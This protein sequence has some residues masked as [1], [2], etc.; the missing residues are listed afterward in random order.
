[1][2]QQ[3][4]RGPAGVRGLRLGRVAG[5]TVTLDWSLLI[6]FALITLMLS[7]GVLPVWHPDWGRFTVLFTAASA[8]VLFLASILVHELSHAVVGRRMGV[9]VEHITLFVFGGMAHMEEEPRTW[10]AELAMAIAGPITSLLLGFA[11]ISLAGLVSGPL[12]VNPEAP[13]ETLSTLNPLATI[14]FWLGPVNIILGLFNMVPGFPLDGGRVLRAILWGVTGDYAGATR[15][16]AAA[17]QAF[18]WLLIASG[19]AMILGFRVPLLG[20]GPVAGLWVALI[21][22]FL[23][24][25]ALMSSRRLLVREGLG[26][27]PVTRVMHTDFVAVAPDLTVR[28]FVDE[29]LLGSSRR[30]FPVVEDGR[31]RGIVCLADVRKLAPDLWAATRVREIMTPEERLQRISPSEKASDALD[32]LGSGGVNQL[33][34]VDAGRLL[35]MVTRED[36]LKWLALSRRPRS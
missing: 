23:N 11:F 18:A 5:V 4:T 10:R 24:N 16:A 12:E 36:L 14:L 29:H 26:D 9:R 15:R 8:A 2:N 19:F 25:A 7:A 20:T 35:G 34:V 33:P 27:L 17:G 28:D 21:G 31:L 13:L 22:W 30:S 3:E 32:R 6:I 1:M